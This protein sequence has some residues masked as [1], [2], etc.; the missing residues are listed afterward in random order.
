MFTAFQM[1]TGEGTLLFPENRLPEAA[2]IL[3]PHVKGKNVSPR[4]KRNTRFIS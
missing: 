4:A 2:L 3:K 1:G